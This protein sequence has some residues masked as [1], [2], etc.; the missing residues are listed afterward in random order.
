[1]KKQRNKRTK[2]M[3]RATVVVL[4][5]GVFAAFWPTQMGGAT[6]VLTTVGTSMEPDIH[7]GDIA[8]VRRSP[9]YHVGDVVAFQHGDF[10]QI[11]LHRIVAFTD[12]V[13]T[14][15]GDNNDFL[16]SFKSTEA[17]IV[18]RLWIHIPGAG[19]WLDWLRRPREVALV[20]M[21]LGLVI[22]TTLKQ[23]R[24]RMRR[25]RAGQPV[26]G[27]GLRRR[28]FAP[29]AVWPLGGATRDLW[30]L[31][32]RI[33]AG[34]LAVGLLL[35][36][37]S[38]SLSPTR[39]ALQPI[40]FTHTGEFSYD[41]PASG[42]QD[43]VPD[44]MRDGAPV[45]LRLAS[46]LRVN[47][48]YELV[49]EHLSDVS[50]TYRLAAVIS[51]ARGWR[52][53]FSLREP[54]PFHGTTFQAAGTLNL[55]SMRV[56]LDRFREQTGENLPSYRFALKAEVHTNGTI[57]GVAL[58]SDFAPELGFNADDIALDPD[59]GED[60]SG[61]KPTASDSVAR[62]AVVPAE[63]RVWR[64]GVGVAALRQ[65]ALALTA[66]ALLILMVALWSRTHAPQER[67][68]QRIAR[69]YGSRLLAVAR[70]EPRPDE[71]LVRMTGMKDLVRIADNLEAPILHLA[72]GDRH[73]YVVQEGDTTY[74]FEV[75]DSLGSEQRARLA[76]LPAPLPTLAPRASTRLP[77]PLLEI[78]LGEPLKPAQPSAPPSSG[79]SGLPPA[80]PRR[81][82]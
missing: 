45:F 44:G 20:T 27:A 37:W 10:N 30:T 57:D 80:P 82:R 31:I 67:A 9:P 35:S 28:A 55:D 78:D 81:P 62:T 12:G 1:M 53:E 5:I 24:K 36:V 33:T 14:T 74:V 32:A 76:P 75:D 40:P 52:R 34:L 2:R 65:V 42:A 79:G 18:G 71:R 59:A 60:E 66:V 7:Q 73:R 70:V 23:T 21:L 72:E 13:F 25:R 22:G 26:S 41:A 38:A 47:F 63:L 49:G 39:K 64:I 54:A 6:A 68:S 4:V 19:R 15:K 69:R 61:F 48:A 29:Q 50:G 8:I 46:Q 17:D 51:D 11:A 3:V 58:S 43:T 56:A 77:A 16:D